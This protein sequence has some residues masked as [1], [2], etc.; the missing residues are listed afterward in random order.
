MLLYPVLRTAFA[1]PGLLL[2]CALPAACGDD[3]SPA[4][5][6]APPAPDAFIPPPVGSFPAGFL[7]GTAVAPYQVEGGLHDNDWHQWETLCPGCSG[8]HADDGPDFWNQYAVDLAN[9]KS[10]HNNAIRLGIDW[11]RVFPTEASF[12]DA[13]DAAAVARYHAI[14]AEARAQGLEPM[15]TLFHFVTPT[16]IHDLTDPTKRGWEDPATIAKFARFAQWA[17]AEFGAEVDWWITI[18]EPIVLV[19][20]GWLSG[21]WPPGKTFQVQTMLDVVGNLAFAH[22]AAYDALHAHDAAD[23]DGDGTA[24]KVSIASHNRVF[25]AKDP[26]SDDDVRAADLLRY[27]N[28]RWFVNAV[29]YGDLDRN[30]DLDADD[31]GDAKGETRLAGRLDWIGLNYYSVSLVVANPGG[32][33]PLV[34]FPLMNDLP[35]QGFDA[36]ITAYGWSI[37]PE[38]LR[39]VLDELRPYDLPIAITENGLA[40][41]NDT[42]RPRWLIDHLYVLAKAIDDGIP[43]EGYFHWSLMDNFEW[44][45]GYCPQFGLFRV[46]RQSPARTRTAGEGAT[47]YRRIIDANTVPP[48]LFAAYPDYG[49]PGG[50][51]TR[52]GL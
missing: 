37:Y 38:G 23:A 45:A 13:P 6:A 34:G 33:F 9:A 35:R 11:S 15:V 48:G 51:C 36:P 31:P 28:N 20:A 46:D 1:W 25:Q 10:L 12:P 18:N 24:A 39:E 52:V 43:V 7:W 2:L 4:V 27:L 8:D 49:P 3:G 47:V 17:A 22:A 40:D 50:Y 30:F 19:M 16:W 29:V 21:D 26:G 32:E 44:S 14:L 42:Q 41:G 5:D